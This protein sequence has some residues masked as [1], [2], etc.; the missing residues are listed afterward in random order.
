MQCFEGN[1]GSLGSLGK[2]VTQHILPAVFSCT[3]ESC[4]SW[5][6]CPESGNS[7]NWFP[8]NDLPWNSVSAGCG[9][10]S[11]FE[12][13]VMN[14]RNQPAD[15]GSMFLATK[16]RCNVPGML[17]GERTDKCCWFGA[18]HTFMGA[19]I[20]NYEQMFQFESKPA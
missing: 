7:P 2:V 13:V 20:V 17:R 12:T 16:G 1:E 9:L 10:V 8:L 3:L 11:Q 5:A 19:V 6:K 18:N 14:R 15:P 4:I